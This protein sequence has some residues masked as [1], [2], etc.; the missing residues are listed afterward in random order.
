MAWYLVKHRHNFTLPL[1]E[2]MLLQRI[3]EPAKENLTGRWMELHYEELRNLCLSRNVIGMIIIR[4][5]RDM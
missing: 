2:K 1:Y 4:N 5:E 3:S